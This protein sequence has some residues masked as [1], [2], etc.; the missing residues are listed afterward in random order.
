M[1]LRIGPRSVAEGWVDGRRLLE[2]G[3][4]TTWTRRRRSLN[5]AASPSSWKG[6]RASS[7]M[8]RHGYE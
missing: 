7:Q 6:N 8:G 5:V 3:V 4:P 1:S 2:A